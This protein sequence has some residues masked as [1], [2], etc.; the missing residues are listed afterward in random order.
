[1]DEASLYVRLGGEAAV[2]AA[3]S[4]FYE[5]LV[6]DELLAR[7]FVGLDIDVLTA[8]QVGFLSRSFGGPKAYQGRPLR[9]SHARLVKEHGLSDQ[10]FDRITLH[11]CE[12]LAELDVPAPL[13]KEVSAIVENTR[14]EVLGR[15]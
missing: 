5:R 14:S 8:K 10:H 6:A 4:T 11:L 3:C 13:I 15:S 2:M 9:Q 1:M 7:F 12:T